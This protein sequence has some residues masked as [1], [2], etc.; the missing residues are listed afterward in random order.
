MI[1]NSYTT[2]IQALAASAAQFQQGAVELNQSFAA[3][4]NKMA[5]SYSGFAIGA[6]SV[7]PA[8]YAAA[9]EASPLGGIM[10]MKTAELAYGAN[11]KALQTSMQ[12]TQAVIDAVA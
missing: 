4:S 5:A 12:M 7:A 2:S 3:A 1:G 10:T 11:L 9:A 8:A 6:T